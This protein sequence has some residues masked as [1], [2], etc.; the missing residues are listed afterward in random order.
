M[1]VLGGVTSEDNAQHLRMISDC[2]GSLPPGV[3]VDPKPRVEGLPYQLPL[4]QKLLKEWKYNRKED[5]YVVVDRSIWGGKSEGQKRGLE[6]AILLLRAMLKTDSSR[7]CT[8][9]EALRFIWVGGAGQEGAQ[10]G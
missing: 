5:K 8:A 3:H 10:G 7:R 1:F 6:D 2:L 4:E 9:E